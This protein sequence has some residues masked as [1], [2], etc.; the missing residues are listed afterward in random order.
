MSDLVA[1]QEEITEEISGKLRLKLTG[2][3]KKAA[4]KRS[5]GSS[6]ALQAYQKGRFHWNKRT[7]Q[8]ARRAVELFE[9]AI[10]IDPNFALAYSGLADSHIALGL[11]LLDGPSAPRDT[12][13]KAKE[14]AAKAISIDENLGEAHASLALA[15]FFFDWNWTKAEEDYKR[16]I[17]LNP[18]YTEAPHTYSH[19]LMSRGRVAESLAMSQRCLEIAP[20]DVILRVHLGW[21]YHNA[22][23]Y[24]KAVEEYRRILE[25]EPNSALTHR[26]LGLTYAA[27]KMY[28]EAIG[29]LKRA[30]S[31]APGA[32]AIV[33]ELGYV[34]AASGKTAEAAGMV[35]DLKKMTG[36]YVSPVYFAMVAAGQG[37]RKA[38]LDWLDKAYLD[39]SDLL[40]NIHVDPVFDGLRAEPRFKE[41]VR[42]I[43]LT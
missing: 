19:F 28:P 4:T 20:S 13:P 6:E 21:H 9:D 24:D 25:S 26:Y 16:A 17:S 8:D 36:R 35:E 7:P 10:R 2:A 1:V 23:Q 15:E 32:A 39:R 37:D 14:A 42:K 11:G 18:N 22:R 43:G 5:T 12:I 38:A 3:E 34:Y 27:K 31:L 41:L 40:V 33:S 30:L 29:E